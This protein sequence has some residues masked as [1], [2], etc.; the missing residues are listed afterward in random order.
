MQ[1][2]VRQLRYLRT[3]Y[4]ITPLAPEN[5]FQLPE[6]KQPHPY[7]LHAISNAQHELEITRRRDLY[8]RFEQELS[9]Y[10]AHSVFKRLPIHTVPY[11]YAFYASKENAT[12]VARLARSAGFD[13]VRW[14]DLPEAV[15]PTAPDHY[16]SLW[17]IN[18]LC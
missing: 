14:P 3:G 4:A 6:G 1:G 5:E 8:R 7:L 9:M 13:C 15:E 11:G 2:V 10:G 12:K 17:M 16:R 18:F